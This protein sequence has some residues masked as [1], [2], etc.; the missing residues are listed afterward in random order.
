MALGA[1]AHNV[2]DTLSTTIRDYLA[3]VAVDLKI[4]ISSV[5][6]ST[7]GESVEAPPSTGVS[8]R[9]FTL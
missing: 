5:E 7:E 4:P 1:D 8:D 3:L 9:N 6:V 2:T